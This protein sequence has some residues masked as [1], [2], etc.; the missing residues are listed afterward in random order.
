[1][2]AVG[3]SQ[4]I[5]EEDNLGGFKADKDSNTRGQVRTNWTVIDVKG[6]INVYS[7]TEEVLGI[8][9]TKV[10]LL[11]RGKDGQTFFQVSLFYILMKDIA[12]GKDVGDNFGTLHEGDIHGVVKGNIVKIILPKGSVGV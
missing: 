1:M 3:I 11:I 9:G 7:R 2:K 10:S 4:H 5:I 12:P 6:I 8:F